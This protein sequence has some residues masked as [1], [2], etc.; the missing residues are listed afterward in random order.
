[1]KKK[2]LIVLAMTMLLA[3]LFAIS[4]FANES[5]KTSVTLSDGTELDLWAED[6]S[7]L[8]WYISGTDAEG[9]NTY[10]CVSNLKQSATS[11]EAYVVYTSKV[12]SSI[13]YSMTGITVYDKDGN[14]YDKTKIVVANLQ[15]TNEKPLCLPK[16]SVG[17]NSLTEKLF[18]NCSE[19]EYVFLPDSLIRIGPSCFYGC[20]SLKELDASN[21]SLQYFGGASFQNCSSLTY[22]A[23]PDCL[24]SLDG[25]SIFDSCKK[26]KTVDGI[27]K[28]LENIAKNR[29]AIPNKLFYDCVELESDIIIYD[30]ITSIG[31]HAFIRCAKIGSFKNL[32]IPNTVLSIG[33][34][35]FNACTQIETANLGSSL[36][37]TSTGY[38]F[39]DCSSLKEI[40]IPTSLA[41]FQ[42]D[43]V[44]SVSSQCVFYFTGT[45][46]QAVNFKTN[47]VSTKN[48]I[49]K[50]ATI[51]SLTEFNNLTEKSGSYLVYG[52][53]ACEA[54]YDGAHTMVESLS[55]TSYDAIGVRKN[56]CTN[57]DCFHFTMSDIE[58]LFFCNGYSAPEGDREGLVVSYIVNVAALKEYS[59]YLAKSGKTLTYGVFAIAKVNLENDV[60][61][62]NGA[63]VDYAVVAEISSYDFVAFDLKIVDFTDEYK[64]EPLAMGAYVAVADVDGK[65]D[66]SYMQ[67]G[68]PKENE[69]YCFV[70]YDEVVNGQNSGGN[71]E[72]RISKI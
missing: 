63:P 39:A 22:V 47:T 40:Y 17:F 32:V 9:K 30:G 28:V 2:I 38:N 5:K 26:L 19:L 51:K 41:G 12:E 34:S 13:Y 8:I 42:G 66:Y 27:N 56:T 69:K 52:Y 25:Q 16:Q 18:Q 68:T 24:D 20:S 50:N 1:M 15:Y 72:I 62:E 37:N 43:A 35:A 60:F 21:T 49:I 31:E 46:D 57:D 65:A 67:Y 45:Y 70:S 14:S 33:R 4:V 48:T 58:P 61:D 7:G 23:L 59:E 36:N 10:G 11:G 3:C 44:R 29:G 55:Y 64:D 53:S 71:N 54:F 6:G